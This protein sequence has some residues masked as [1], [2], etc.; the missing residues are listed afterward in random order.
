M[1]QLELQIKISMLCT[2]FL[3]VF[4]IRILSGPKEN[5]HRWLRMATVAASLLHVWHIAVDV[6]HSLNILTYI[7]ISS[8]FAS[9]SP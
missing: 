6:V 9:E 1:F 4:L 5:P 8:P 3:H 7:P 2:T